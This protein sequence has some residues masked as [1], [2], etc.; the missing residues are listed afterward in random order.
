[1]DSEERRLQHSLRIPAQIKVK[2]IAL[3]MLAISGM[4]DR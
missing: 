4:F 1:M 2:E 3:H